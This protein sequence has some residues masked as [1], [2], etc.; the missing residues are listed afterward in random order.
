MAKR[1]WKW[2]NKRSQIYFGYSSNCA[3]LWVCQRQTPISS[4]YKNDL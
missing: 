3:A 1:S 2:Y 4:W